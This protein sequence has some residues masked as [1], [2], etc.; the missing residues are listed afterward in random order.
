MA[1]GLRLGALG[2]MVY[3]CFR[4]GFSSVDRRNLYRDRLWE[5]PG[6]MRGISLDAGVRG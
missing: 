4:A 5:V 3:G 1:G 6:I 2:L